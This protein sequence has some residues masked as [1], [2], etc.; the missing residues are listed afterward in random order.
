MIFRKFS[1]ILSKYLAI[2]LCLI[3]VL[4][5][6][7]WGS[8]LTVVLLNNIDGITLDY[9]SGSLVRDVQLNSL[10]L[11]LD[12]L[13]ISVKNLSTEI[14]FVCTWKKLLCVRSAKADYFSLDYQ[15]NKE[16][17]K[18]TQ[19]NKNLEDDKARFHVSPEG[20]VLITPEM[21]G[22]YTFPLDG[23]SRWREKS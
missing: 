12:N 21:L 2:A 7:P 3:T 14:N 1:L 22:Q 17:S 8:H 6:T 23:L 10:H 20:G 9:H 4:L 16:Q 11:Q 13:D 15:S 18:N 5:T 19:S